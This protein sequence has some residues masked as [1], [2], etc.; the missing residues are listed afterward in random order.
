MLEQALKEQ[1]KSVFANLKNTYTFRIEVADSH[2]NKSELIDLLSDVAS[3]S[4]RIGMEITSGPSLAFRIAQNG[5][6]SNVVFRAVPNGHEFTT[7]LLAVLNK[8]GIGKNLPDETIVARIKAL[9][10]RVEL[11]SYISLTCTNCPDVV[12]ALNVM[13]FH[14]PN[15][16]HD[17]IDGG[18]NKE[19]VEAL[20]I[21]AVPSVFLNGE[22][23]HVG[24]SSIG[25]LLDKIEKKV[26]TEFS[27]ENQPAKEYDVIVIGGGPAGSSAAI[28][29]ARKG[30]RVAL[31]AQQVGG[32][33]IETV[34]IENM[35]S[36]TKTTGAQL[37]ASLKNHLSDYPV[38]IL[39]N[40]QVTQVS[41]VDGL[42][43][44]QTSMGEKL[45]APSIIVSTGASWRRLNVAG[46]Q[47]YIGAGVAFCA[48]C[49]GPFY[50]NKR[51]AV[52]GGGNSGLEAALDLSSLASEVT[53]LE[54]MDELK[55]DQVLQ[56]KLKK[57][58]NVRIVTSA[59]TMSIEG[60]GSKVTSIQLK[61]RHTGQ[62]EEV[63]LDGVFVQIGLKA[64]TSVFADI[65]KLAP[66]GEIVIDAHCRTS[67]PGIYAA[68]DATT[69]PYK[70]IVVAMGE[71]AK[72][73]LSSFE[74]Y[75]KG[76]QLAN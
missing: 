33:L 75:L 10:G 63:Q 21:Q 56:D 70:Q 67:V 20:Q 43:H 69:V 11:K 26:G 19:E 22:M 61:H 39:E 66:T 58:P 40:R 28:Y 2:P 3:C 8:D 59:Q 27:I 29:S 60:D 12:Q 52:V 23:L 51:V 6:P 35:I 32:Q 71:G 64:N 73:A 50:K 55:G 68:G 49:D 57:V 9:K 7:L 5:E 42:K 24:R 37:T 15:I 1:V 47:Q 76:T 62:E 34:G 13:A 38:D 4:D 14:N 18:I 45:V 48:H 41:L 65:L 72:A 17:I 74:D 53:L 16:Q 25:E 46:E 31:V 54:Y 30:L 36:I 44:V